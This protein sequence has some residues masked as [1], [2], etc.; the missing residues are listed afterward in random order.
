LNAD[1]YAHTELKQ[2]NLCTTRRD[3]QMPAP[4]GSIAN[5]SVTRK[6]LGASI[7]KN[8]NA[9]VLF[10]FLLSLARAVLP[11]LAAPA[12]IAAR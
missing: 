8:S 12:T 6:S 10:N 4:N 3:R 1:R 7:D 2:L 9:G 5:L 11:A